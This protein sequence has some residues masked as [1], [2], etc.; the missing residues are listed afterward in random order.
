M[1]R[2]LPFL[3]RRLFNYMC[4]FEGMKYFLTMVISSFMILS[5]FIYIISP[6]DLIPEAMFGVV[7]LVDDLIA[8]LGLII[9][10]A[11]NYYRFLS[12]RA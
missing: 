12:I 6:F 2:D 9:V 11:N 1:I 5:L 3:L 10:I 7:G 4:T 8:L